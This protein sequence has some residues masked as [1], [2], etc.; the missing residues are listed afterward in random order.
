MAYRENFLQ[1]SVDKCRD[2][3]LQGPPMRAF[4]AEPGSPRLARPARPLL[5]FA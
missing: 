5:M 3:F 1:L 4:S 2:F